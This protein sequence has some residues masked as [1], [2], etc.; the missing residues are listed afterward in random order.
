MAGNLEP[1]LR[2]LPVDLGS[3]LSR[4]AEYLPM[5]L[6]EE[7]LSYENP[8]SILE[9]LEDL[10]QQ[11]VGEALG[12]SLVM[13]VLQH[14][15][16]TGAPQQRRRV[17]SILTRWSPKGHGAPS[18]QPHERRDS[19]VAVRVEHAKVRLSAGV[20]LIRERRKRGGYHRDSPETMRE[21]RRLGYTHQEI[22]AIVKTRITND[23]SGAA[24]H[25]V[26]AQDGTTPTIVRAMTS[27]GKKYL[28]S[29]R[30]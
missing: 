8:E 30:P 26:A 14:F 24:Y 28:S 9:L 16:Q 5:R 25:L 29:V 4:Q 1:W 2:F 7:V 10:T 20:T 21:L 22:Q 12:V 13:E 11:E 15:I 19:T 18:K 17:K 3:W 6:H 27:R 23:S